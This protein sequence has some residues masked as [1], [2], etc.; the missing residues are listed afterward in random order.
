MHQIRR[1]IQLAVSISRCKVSSSSRSNIF[2]KP[3]T[4]MAEEEALPSSSAEEG[5]SFI[6]V[7][8]S[9]P[10]TGQPQSQKKR[11]KALRVLTWNVLCSNSGQPNYFTYCKA[12]DLQFSNRSAKILKTTQNVRPAIF[13]LQELDKIAPGH[14][15]GYT[16]EL[17]SFGYGA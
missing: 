7:D 2:K 3:G 16:K 10:H 13:C 15:H 5:R 17:Q 1:N 12:E 11:Q 14:R 9:L 8:S 6:S 4:R